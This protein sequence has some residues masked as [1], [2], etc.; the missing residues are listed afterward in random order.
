MQ[1]TILFGATQIGK[2]VSTIMAFQVSKKQEIKR[3]A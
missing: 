1:A 3:A 2:H